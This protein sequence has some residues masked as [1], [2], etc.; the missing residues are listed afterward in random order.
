MAELV[1][2]TLFK[3]SDAAELNRFFIQTKPEARKE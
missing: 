3:C 2:V 1:S